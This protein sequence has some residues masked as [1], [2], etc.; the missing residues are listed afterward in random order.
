[1][2]ASQL[3]STEVITVG[4]DASIAEA[5]RMMLQ[6]RIS[7][8]PVIDSANRLTGIV[9]EGDLL[10]RGEIGTDRHHPLWPRAH[11]H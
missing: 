5:I 4:R 11:M 1:M 7:G 3:M 2:K 6:H 8:L 9:T 10:R